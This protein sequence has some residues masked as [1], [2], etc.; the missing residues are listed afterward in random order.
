MKKTML[1]IISL[2]A[3]FCA[4]HACL[5]AATVVTIKCPHKGTVVCVTIPGHG[6]MGQIIYGGPADIYQSSS[7]QMPAPSCPSSGSSDVTAFAHTDAS[8]ADV[9]VGY[10]NGVI[11]VSGDQETVTMYSENSP[12]YTSYA[13][14]Y[15]NLP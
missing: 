1:G 9:G 7:Y 8:N 2:L 4:S 3:A 5:T 12:T 6:G 15:S 14:W 13:T 11:C 10:I